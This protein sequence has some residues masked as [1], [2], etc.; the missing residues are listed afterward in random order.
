MK[1]G[2]TSAFS[3]P[4]LRHLATFTLA[5]VPTAFFAG[6]IWASLNGKIEGHE[7]ALADH[8]RVLEKM[9]S[10]IAPIERALADGSGAMTV[11]TQGEDIKDIKS[12][13]ANQRELNGALQAQS[14]ATAQSVAEVKGQVTSLQSSVNNLV[15]DVKAVLRNLRGTEP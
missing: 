9:D 4:L 10:R 1:D 14:Q 15:G 6:V 13:V 5:V 3:N 11:R 2:L 7:N 12:F 8:S